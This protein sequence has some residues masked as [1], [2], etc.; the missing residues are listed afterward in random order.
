MK[1][2]ITLLII[3]ATASVAAEQAP[4]ITCP[5]ENND[6]EL[7]LKAQKDIT[8][9]YQSFLADAEKRL[10]VKD[11]EIEQLTRQIQ[12]LQLVNRTLS[13]QNQRL[14]DTRGRQ[15]SSDIQRTMR[16]IVH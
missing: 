3:V 16:L 6:L 15:L 11:Q 4:T 12:K 9:I 5:V 2:F 8:E 7:R 10:E 14:A 1:R 13:D